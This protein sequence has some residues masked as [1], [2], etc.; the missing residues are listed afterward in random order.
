MGL[1]AFLDKIGLSPAN[2]WGLGFNALGGL[3]NLFGGNSAKKERNKLLE[4]MGRL[5]AQDLADRRARWAKEDALERELENKMS[6]NVLAT[7]RKAE[8]FIPI[9]DRERQELGKTHDAWQR[10]STGE[11]LLTKGNDMRAFLLDMARKKLQDEPTYSTR[12]KDL[13]RIDKGLKE[14]SQYQ[15]NFAKKFGL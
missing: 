13:E 3:I 1:E 11:D 14:L 6:K 7:R 9:F 10:T 2:A 8:N 5:K 12:D 4:Q 15:R